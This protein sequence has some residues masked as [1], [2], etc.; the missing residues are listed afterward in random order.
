MDLFTGDKNLELFQTKIVTHNQMS[1]V[2]IT[3]V[4][5]FKWH[6]K[7]NYKGENTESLS[8]ALSS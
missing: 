4:A 6:S 8:K 5:D 2:I 1:T 7:I 3:L